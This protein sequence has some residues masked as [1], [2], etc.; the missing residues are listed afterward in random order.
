MQVRRNAL[1]D[2]AMDAGRQL[3][4]SQDISTKFGIVFQKRGPARAGA[5]LERAEKG[6]RRERHRGAAAQSRRGREPLDG[7]LRVRRGRPAALHSAARAAAPAAQSRGDILGNGSSM[8]AVAHGR[9]VASALGFTAHE[10]GAHGRA[11]HARC[12]R[13]PTNRSNREGGS[14]MNKLVTLASAAALAIVSAF[15]V[16][17]STDSSTTQDAS[18]ATK[19]AKPNSKELMES[20]MNMQKG[21]PSKT[22]TQKEKQMP[23]Y[24]PT[25]K[26]SM[27][28]QM[29]MQKG[30]PSPAVKNQT[31]ADKPN[32]SKMT[33]EERAEFRKDVVKDAKP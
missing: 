23:K 17:Q 31:Y 14:Q 25:A 3:A 7:R 29:N 20:Q 13:C 21:K 22:V 12:P 11:P 10:R 4:H 2:D 26:D 24:R 27:E 15:A 16:A 5:V 1:R 6:V 32:A 9:N 30:K 18:K 28:S 19:P 8:C 33:P